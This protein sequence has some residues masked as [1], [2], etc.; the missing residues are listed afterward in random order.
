MTITPGR[1]IDIGVN[2]K[3][4]VDNLNAVSE[5]EL[6]EVINNA[7]MEQ[8]VGPMLDPTAFLGGEKFKQIHLTKRV[9][10]AILQFK[11]E[12]SGIGSFK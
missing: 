4:V 11:K 10:T 7:N 3:A 12:V 8:T 6:E 1:A 9:M 5:E 2:L